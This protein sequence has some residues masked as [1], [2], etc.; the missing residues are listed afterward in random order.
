MFPLWI[1]SQGSAR[2]GG[3]LGTNAGGVQ[4]LAFGNARELCLGVEAV[5]AD[6]RLYRGSMRCKKDNT[7]YDLKDLLVGAEGTLGII[8]AATLKLFPQPE[9]HETAFCSVA[10]PGSGAG[11]VLSDARAHRLAADG[12][13]ADAALRARSAAQARDAGAR[14][15]ARACRR[16]T[17]WSRSTA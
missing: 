7:G 12:V 11:A 4:V 1:A 17:R 15:D 13:R 8:T 16:G 2:I 10:E 14:P 5:L 9:G 3:V 6:G